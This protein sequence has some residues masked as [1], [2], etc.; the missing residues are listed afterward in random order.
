MGADDKLHKDLGLTHVF[1]IA[2]GAMIGSGLFILPG[3][4]HAMAGPGVIFSYVLAGLLATTGALSIAELA[5]AMP[6]AGS[7][8]FFIMRGFGAATGSIAGML[9][10]FSLSLKSAFAIVG[11]ATFVNMILHLP[12]LLSGAILTVFFIALNI[13]GV[14]EAARMQIIIVFGLLLILVVYVVIG[15]PQ[16]SAELLIPFAPYG[17]IPIVSTAGFVFVSYGGLLKVASIAE[18]VRN[19]GR[20][21]PLG[22]ALAL[23]LVTLLYALT[24]MVTS[25]LVEDAVL[26]NSLTPISDGGRVLMGQFGFV[27]MSIAAILAFVST[28]NAGIMASSRYLLALGRDDLLPSTLSKISSRFRTPHVA[29]LVTGTLI[30][31]SLF[32]KLNVLVEAASCVLMLTY[33]L[34]CLAV[35]VLRESGLQ[36]YRPTFKSP[37]YPWVQIVGILG[38]GF[39]LFELGITAFIISA[40]LILIAFLTFWFYGREGVERESALLHLV[41]R[42]TDRQLVHGALEEELKQIIRDRDKIVVDRFDRL[43]ENAVILDITEPM[44]KDDFFNLVAEHLSPRLRMKPKRLARCLQRREAE[45]STVLSP[46]LAV[47]HLIVDSEKCFDLLI[48][49]AHKGIEFNDE[50][51]EVHAVFVLAGSAD[52]RNFHLKALSAIAQVV[53]EK[54]FEERWWAAKN[55]QGLRDVILLSTRSRYDAV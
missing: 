50:A 3:M 48:V 49:R 12:G 24:V 10:W 47:P 13:L 43:V 26:D 23:I 6:K 53:Q 32:L 18:E 11:M 54:K 7:D 9:S 15:F 8:Y 51:R 37:L 33:I 39:V 16:T 42:L 22:L 36:N 29:I 2:S 52:E 25:G 17:M 55:E 4:A 5:T 20:N 30:L 46:F 40:G 38:I 41:A 34:S 19:P 27:I 44:S 45:T 28:A 31:L 21:M 1:T 14:R 35:I